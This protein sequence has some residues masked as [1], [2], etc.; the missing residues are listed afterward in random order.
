M[1]RCV[2]LLARSAGSPA[3]NQMTPAAVLGDRALRCRR[4]DGGALVVGTEKLLGKKLVG[5]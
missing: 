1:R 4:E 5:R 3:S 2:E